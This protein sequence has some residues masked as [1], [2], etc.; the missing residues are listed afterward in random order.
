MSVDSEESRLSFSSRESSYSPPP[1]LGSMDLFVYSSDEESVSSCTSQ[2]ETEYESFD[3][4]LNGVDYYSVAQL[5]RSPN[6]PKRPRIDPDVDLDLRPIAFVRFNA[7][8]GKMKPITI[9]ALL[10]SGA[11]E[12]LVDAKFTKKLNVKTTKSGNA[13]WSTP[14]GSLTTNQR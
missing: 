4:F 3:E 6:N 5:V 12:S 11:A 9:K 14:A 2:P 10:D 13:K 7:R 8:R 1:E